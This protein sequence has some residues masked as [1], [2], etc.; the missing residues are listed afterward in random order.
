MKKGD[1]VVVRGYPNTRLQRVVWSSHET[2]VL[3]CRPDVYEAA[4]TKGHDPSDTMGFPIE[5]VLEVVK[6]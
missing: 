2:Y 6:Q 1:W 3:V 4:I 5:D